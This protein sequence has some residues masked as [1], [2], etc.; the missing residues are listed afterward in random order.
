MRQM[1]ELPEK[2]ALSNY[3]YVIYFACF[4][5]LFVTMGSLRTMP[6]IISDITRIYEIKNIATFM[7]PVMFFG[8]LLAPVV[9]I[10]ASRYGAR[11]ICVSLAILASLPTFVFFFS[12]P[13]SFATSNDLHFTPPYWLFLILMSLNSAGISALIVASPV[14]VNK[15][16]DPNKKTLINAFVWMGGSVGSMIFPVVLPIIYKQECHMF[17]MLAVWGAAQF[18]I[19]TSIGFLYK[20]PPDYKFKTEDRPNFRTLTQYK[21]YIAF[22]FMIGGHQVW[23]NGY[24]IFLVPYVEEYRSCDFYQPDNLNCKTQYTMS[25][26]SIEKTDLN[27]T[28]ICTAE[29]SYEQEKTALL[30]TIMAAVE[31]FARPI[32][33]RLC[34]NKNR[35]GVAGLCSLVLFLATVL[36]GFVETYWAMACLTGI[37]GL[38]NGALGGLWMTIIVD[39][40]GVD[41]ARHGYSLT[42]IQNFVITIVTISIYGKGF[43]IHPP[44][45]FWLS[46][47][48]MLITFIAGMVGVAWREHIFTEKTGEK[49]EEK[50]KME[51]GNILE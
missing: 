48:G 24:T 41:L 26:S 23:R 39:S 31:I 14:E 44:S 46:S 40:V 8:C 5:N 34:E 29:Q 49:E 21:L 1:D 4:M 7:I 10:V 17:W 45:V 42:Q 22:L 19:L 28:N 13:E 3:R 20:N 6:L 16:C 11:K 18:V 32:F 33:G 47:I 9:A 51:C 37:I 50:I 2:S 12:K 38:F 15:W 27:A 35:F 30:L 36:S 25:N 43:E